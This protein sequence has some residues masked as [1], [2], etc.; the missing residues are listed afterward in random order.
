MP[1]SRARLRTDGPAYGI[2]NDVSGVLGAAGGANG[3][4][5][6]V[7]RAGAA[8]ALVA[9]GGADTAG[10]TGS[11]ATPA[12]ST[13][14]IRM[15]VPSLT[16]SPILTASDLTTPAAGEGTSM[17]ALSDSSVISGASAAIRSPGFTCIS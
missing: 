4:L 17:E 13:S 10:F 2:S 5:G 15:G 14:S 11:L 8:G 3:M 9:A 1:R 7:A 6:G 12:P 16:L